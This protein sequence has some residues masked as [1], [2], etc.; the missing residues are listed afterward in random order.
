MS[1]YVRCPGCGNVFPVHGFERE[2][3]C[4]DCG[5]DFNPQTN[6]CLERQ[7]ADDYTPYDER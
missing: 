6:P 3:H 7:N 4:D 5:E 1:V 2:A